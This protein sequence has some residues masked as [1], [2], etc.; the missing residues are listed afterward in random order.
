[1]KVKCFDLGNDERYIPELQRE[2]EMG[3]HSSK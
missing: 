3:Q 2:F 1:M